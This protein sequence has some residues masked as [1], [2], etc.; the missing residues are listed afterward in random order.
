MQRCCTFTFGGHHYTAALA[1]VT[2]CFY[3]HLGSTSHYVYVRIRT[4]AGWQVIQLRRCDQK[5][6]HLR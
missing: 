4:L 1:V 5:L 3:Y 6:T 2:A